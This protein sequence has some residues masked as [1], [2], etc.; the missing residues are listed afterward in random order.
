VEAAKKLAETADDRAALA[1]LAVADPGCIFPWERRRPAGTLQ[2]KLVGCRRD[3]GAPRG[4]R[5]LGRA[6]W[7]KP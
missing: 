1:A 3:A 7:R 2:K 6:R 4:P 5:G